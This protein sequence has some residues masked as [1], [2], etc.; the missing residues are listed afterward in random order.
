MYTLEDVGG[1]N[2]TNVE[3]VVGW[4]WLCC[5]ALV[6]RVWSGWRVVGHV[7]CVPRQAL[8]CCRLYAGTSV[9]RE[10]NHQGLS[11]GICA[12]V[13]KLLSNF[14]TLAQIPFDKP[15]TIMTK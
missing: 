10:D 5:S 3:R 11:K 9:L 7:G 14:A 6:I 4:R 12:S 13:A 15:W 8:K 1:N 2:T